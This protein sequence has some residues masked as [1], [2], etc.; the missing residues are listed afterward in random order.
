MFELAAGSI[1]AVKLL[2]EP[3]A[4]LCFIVL[5]DVRLLVKFVG[6]VGE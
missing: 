1:W 6:A 5:G 4:K 3:F 2:M